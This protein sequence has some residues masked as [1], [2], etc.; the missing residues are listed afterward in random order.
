MA[1]Q[2]P[3]VR[4]LGVYAK[5]ATGVCTAIREAFERNDGA[6]RYWSLVDSQGTSEATTALVLRCTATEARLVFRADNAGDNV[7]CSYH[8][9][10]N[11]DG[12]TE[13][14]INLSAALYSN[15][16]TIGT[17]ELKLNSNNTIYKIS[18]ATYG[19]YL[20]TSPNLDS[21]FVIEMEDAITIV[22]KGTNNTTAQDNWV[23][24]CHAGMVISPEN[25]NDASYGIDG[26][27]IFC[28]F[29]G[30]AGSIIHWAQPT[31]QNNASLVRIGPSSWSQPILTNVFPP[32]GNYVT[33]AQI[34]PIGD[35]GNIERLVPCRIYSD[36]SGVIGS[37]RYLRQRYLKKAVA[38]T[39]PALAS[40]HL[41]DKDNMI[42]GVNDK[43]VLGSN[44]NI[45]WIH[46]VAYDAVA[47]T[48]QQNA[49]HIWNN[50]GHVS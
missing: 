14:T 19:P 20:S 24:S 35:A 40:A 38:V 39:T 22:F 2:E 6:S 23:Y 16:T 33:P 10:P 43:I 34:A 4:R 36:D 17:S 11:N 13:E 5:T 30:F 48:A 18:H 15:L 27:G 7:L 31:N 45:A 25:L 37:M 42:V 49:V 28:G 32:I 8:P 46:Q 9:A 41:S 12:D 3:I 50:N 44:P 26:S 47:Q 29:Y 21:G 1:E